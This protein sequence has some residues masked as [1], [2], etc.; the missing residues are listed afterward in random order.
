M[1]LR[2]I[3]SGD[4]VVIPQTLIVQFVTKYVMGYRIIHVC[5]VVELNIILVMEKKYNVTLDH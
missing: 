3:I 2:Y 4:N 1:L 5:G